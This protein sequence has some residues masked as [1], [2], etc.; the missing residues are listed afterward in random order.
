MNSNPFF[1]LLFFF[2]FYSTA[3]AWHLKN[4]C[5]SHKR[6]CLKFEKEYTKNSVTATSLTY[7]SRSKFSVVRSCAGQWILF[8]VTMEKD[9]HLMVII[10]E[11]IHHLFGPDK[12]LTW[13]A[14]PSANL[15]M[16]SF[17]SVTDDINCW[18]SESYLTIMCGYFVKQVFFLYI[19]FVL[20]FCS[21]LNLLPMSQTTWFYQVPFSINMQ[22]ETHSM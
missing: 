2:F 11:S 15:H 4:H 3:S 1:F 14:K 8:W 22:C 13:D 6:T 9:L 10:L 7:K 20:S 18:L 19:S 16:V 5:S 21:L 12:I 17:T